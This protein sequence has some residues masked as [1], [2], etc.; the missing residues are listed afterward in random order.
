MFAPPIRAPKAKAASQAVPTRARAESLTDS[1]SADHQRQEADPERIAGSEDVPS[2]PWD[3]GSQRSSPLTAFPPPGTLQPNLVVGQVDDPLEHEADRVADQVLRVREPGKA[4]APATNSGP[5]VQRACACGGGCSDCKNK[6]PENERAPVQMKA[7]GPVGK[8]G[9]EASPVVQE[10]LRSSGQPLN[11]ATRAFMEPRFGHDFSRVRIHTDTE[12]AQSAGQLQAS[13][14]NVG[15]HIVFAEGRFAPSTPEGGRLLAHE[16]AH[17]VLGAR[18]NAILRRKPD[19]KDLQAEEAKLRVRIVDA[20]EATKKSAVDA[21]ASAI[22]RGDR[23]YL[24]GLGLNSRQADVLLK[25]TPQFNMEFG[26]AVELKIEQA[27]RADPILS[28]HVEKGPRTVPKG[29]GKPDWI[30]QTPSSSI[31]V[32]L[33]TAEQLDKKQK[34][35]RSQHP[36]GKPKW[37]VE[38]SVNLIYDIPSSLTAPKP[39]GTGLPAAVPGAAAPEIGQAVSKISRFRSAGRFLAREAP[40]L[41]GQALFMLLFPPGVHI[42]NDKADEIGRKK[43]EPAI[44]AALPELEPVFDKL[45][46]LDSSKLIYANVRV[47]LVY[48]AD[49]DRHGHLHLYLDDAA[50]VEM[51]ITNDYIDMPDRKF[52]AKGR[53]PTKEITYSLL[54]YEPES[55]I[56][57]REAAKADQEYAEWVRAQPN[58]KE[59]VRAQQEYQECVQRYGTGRIPPA[60]GA[61]AAQENPEQGPCIPPRMKPMEGP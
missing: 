38:K 41:I 42:H 40:G 57:E 25:K 31:A 46:D 4:V 5:G 61:D 13:A 39:P 16:L 8:T 43:I 2:V 56:R 19:P 7:A 59:W 22:K 45:L 18:Q 12:A 11:G 50:F 51:K 14:Y 26:T 28:Q 37:Y 24:E 27:I 55:V 3:F 10:V 35:W 44:N 9:M 32:E 29:V 52:D 36:K 54:L 53:K 33:T 17:I 6:R 34:M 60:A 30:I 58:Y 21:V 1:I 23:A 49:A 48:T 47:M 15:D 20:L